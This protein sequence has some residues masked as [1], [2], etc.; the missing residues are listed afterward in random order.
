MKGELSA[1]RYDEWVK[2]DRLI[3]PLEKGRQKRRRKK[4]KV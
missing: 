3:W 4:V 2:A 1:L